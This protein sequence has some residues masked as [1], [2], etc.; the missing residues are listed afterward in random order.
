MRDYIHDKVV[1]IKKIYKTNDPFELA[2]ELGVT[3]SYR[4]NFKILKGYFIMMN[5]YPY[6]VVN[7]NLDYNEQR[8][9]VAHDS[10]LRTSAIIQYF[11]PQVE[12]VERKGNW[13]VSL[14]DVGKKGVWRWGETGL[15]AAT[16]GKGTREEV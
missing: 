12:L 11:I 1:T 2:D 16:A 5:G 9:I 8:M 6:I 13:A 3:I 4:N 14:Q 10:Y 15:P 7:S